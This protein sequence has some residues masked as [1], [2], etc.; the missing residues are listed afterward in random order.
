MS[1]ITAHDDA[2]DQDEHADGQ[3]EVNP[4]WSVE[5]ERNDGPD[6]DKYDGDENAEIHGVIVECG[7]RR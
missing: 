1:S 6:Y 2:P 7:R 5:A 3:E 4:S